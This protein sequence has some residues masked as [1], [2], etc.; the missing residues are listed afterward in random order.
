MPTKAPTATQR[1][2]ANSALQAPE[3]WKHRRRNGAEGVP[4]EEKG[5]KQRKL[6]GLGRA[7]GSE[8]GRELEIQK[9]NQ[10]LLDNRRKWRESNKTVSKDVTGLFGNLGKESR[11]REEDASWVGEPAWSRVRGETEDV[12]K[13]RRLG[14]R[15]RRKRARVRI[16]SKKDKEGRTGDHKKLT[17]YCSQ[18]VGVKRR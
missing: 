13:R 14:I 6:Q 1:V 10:V 11:V 2:N 4:P 17:A 8:N 7:K 3:E 12:V 5:G 9:R 15:H 18:F 16:K